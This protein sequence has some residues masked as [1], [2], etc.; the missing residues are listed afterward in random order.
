MVVGP[1]S[2][3][4]IPPLDSS[5]LALKPEESDFFKTLTNIW[6]DDELKRHIIGVQ[7]KAYEVY[8]YPCIRAFSFTKLKI[9]RFPVYKEVLQLR[10]RYPDAILLDVGCCFGND[11]RRAVQDGWLVQNIIGADLEADFWKYGHELFKSSPDTFPAAFIPGD[12]FSPEM[13]QLSKPF[14]SPTSTPRPDNLQTLRSL[15]P[16]QGH[17]SAIHASSLFHL[18]DEELQMTLAKRLA[19]LLSPE[20]GSVIFGSHGGHPQKESIPNILGHTM[21]CHSPESWSDLWNGQVF[22]KGS[23]RVETQLIQTRRPELGRGGL[24]LHL[25]VWSVTRL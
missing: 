12:L 8:S 17:V 14:Y 11:L 22:Q 13:I 9:F 24:D 1:P 7:T 2:L 21:F 3:P 10:D 6:D 20:P 16:L 23:V 19:S 5:L 25:L 4:E 18:F 15:T